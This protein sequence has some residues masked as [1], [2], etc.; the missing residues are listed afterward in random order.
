MCFKLMIRETG[1]EYI[2]W[3]RKKSLGFIFERKKKVSN[4][5][6]NLYIRK[7]TLVP[8]SSYLHCIYIQIEQNKI[9]RPWKKI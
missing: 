3:K 2:F 8:I 1:L 7:K 5:N 9:D 4:F 6:N